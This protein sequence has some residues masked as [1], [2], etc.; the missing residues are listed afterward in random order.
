MPPLDPPPPPQTKGT[1]VGQNK[2]YRREHLIGPFLV[3][4]RAGPRPPS[5][6]LLSSNASFGL[7]P[8]R[9]TKPRRCRGSP[10]LTPF[11]A[12]GRD[13]NCIALSE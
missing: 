7:P 5:P 11:R 13:K 2:M 9:A 4:S 12:E 1:I 3:H 10:T 8:P 6:P